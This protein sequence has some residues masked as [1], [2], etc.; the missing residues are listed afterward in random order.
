MG[1]DLCAGMLEN[2]I[3]D[4]SSLMISQHIKEVLARNDHSVFKS[5]LL[6]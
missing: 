4:L 5:L 2:V 3:N 6:L 1:L